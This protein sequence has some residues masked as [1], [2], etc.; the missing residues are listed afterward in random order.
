[1]TE[2]A[3]AD[4]GRVD[5]RTRSLDQN[6]TTKNGVSATA[7]AIM[8]CLAAAAWGLDGVVLTPRL[9]GL[10]VGFVVLLLHAV[11]FAIMLL[12][13]PGRW[14]QLTRLGRDGWFAVMAVAATGGLVGT[15]AIVHALFLVG[16]NQLSVVVLLQKLQPVFA[17]VLAAVLLREPIDRRLL[18][19]AAIALSGAYLLTF[20]LAPPT[21]SGSS[22]GRAA[23]FAVVA[24]AAFGAATVLGKLLLASVDF[25]TATFARYGATTVLALAW[26]A[27]SGTGLPFDEVAPFQ[28]LLVLVI[29]LT[30]GSGAI[31]L[32]YRGLSSIRVSV[33]TICELCLPLTAVLLD[34][35]VNGSRLGGWQWLGAALLVGSIVSLSG[36]PAFVTTDR[37]ANGLR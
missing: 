8:V 16:F 9:A 31:F 33:A 19:L 5:I 24:A 28:W 27:V 32:Y 11:P 36:R 21:I 12:V 30:T 7:G 23:L 1:M 15:L 10:P 17:I 13:L 29:S 3:A 20:G 18:R 6:G 34:H 2:S 25:A 4:S 14:R 37:P 35:I 26:V 22:V